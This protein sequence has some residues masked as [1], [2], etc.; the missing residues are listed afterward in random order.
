VTAQ[1]QTEAAQR[2]GEERFAA[3]MRHLPGA[4]WMKDLQGR[5]LLANPKAEEIFGI[6]Q[7]QIQGRTDEEIFPPDT[8]RRFR[9]NDLR[10]L[11]EGVV[12]ATEVLRQA[13]GVD[14]YSVV[15]KFAVPGP[16]GQ[17]AC[18]GG[19]A[20]DITERK[21]AEEELQH[22]NRT[23]EQR[24]AERTAEAEQGAEEL[25]ALAGEL[26][27]TEQRER[28]RLAQWLHDDL[29]QLL[30]ATK[31]QIALTQAAITKPALRELLQKATRLIDESIGQSRS[32]TAELSSP[33]LYESGLVPGLE[34]LGRWIE[35]KHGLRV[36]IETRADVTPEHQETAIVLFGATRE[37]LFNVVLPH[38]NG[39]EA[40]QR[41]KSELPRV[42]GLSMRGEKEH[43]A[44]MYEA[45]AAAYLNKGGP[46]EELLMTIRKIV[47]PENGQ[48]NY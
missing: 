38:M 43:G 10:A 8:A 19:V 47:R 37:L 3:F 35:E 46:S 44:A 48:G 45:G 7:R 13:D 18:I 32:L 28:Q 36:T 2:E 24:V 14:H 33:I 39:I 21:R 41:I 40:T 22:I 11:A 16:D 17:A 4:A 5:Y 12:E 29:Q 42:I 34:Q 15:S 26:A 6:T 25:R 27:R 23:L 20:F 31:M 9:E 30:V 1:K